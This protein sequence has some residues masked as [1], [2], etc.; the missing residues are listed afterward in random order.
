MIIF[1]LLI[2]LSRYVS[3]L[4]R[5]QTLNVIYF[6]LKIRFST[7]KLVEIPEIGVMQVYQ[8]I[9]PELITGNRM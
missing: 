9:W 8:T 2:Q 4:L 1:R 5:L 3:I 7:R 6:H